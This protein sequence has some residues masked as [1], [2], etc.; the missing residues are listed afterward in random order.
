[1]SW[2]T[3]I[4]SMIAS[5]CFTLA[6]VHLLIWR[7][8]RETRAHAFFALMAVGTI[9]IAVCEVWSMHAETTAEYGVILR[10]GHV[11]YFMLVIS[12]VGFVR[13][14]LRAGKPWLAWA[15]CGLRTISLILNFIFTPN[16]NYREITALRQV[17]FLGE[18]ISI[19]EGVPNPWMLIGQASLLLL[20]I[21]TIDAMLT[22]WRRH[23]RRSA[24]VLSITIM[25]FV[26]MNTGQFVLILWGVLH[27]PLT[28]SIFFL[29]I[30][31]AMSFDLSDNVLRVVRL[32][33]DLRESEERMT[34]AANAV[35]FG[36]WIWNVS[37]DKVWCTGKLRLL[38]GFEPGEE[39]TPNLFF[40]RLHPEDHERVRQTL[41]KAL[42]TRSEYA[43]EY[44]II[45]SDGC[46]RWIAAFG[47]TEQ[48][49]VKKEVRMLGVCMDITQRKQMEEELRMS[50]ERYRSFIANSSESISR[51]DFAPPIPVNLPEKDQVDLIFERGFLVECNAMTA[52]QYGFPGVDEAIGA[53]L[54]M[55][56][57]RTKAEN[58]DFVLAW[59]RGHYCLTNK[60]SVEFDQQEN[61]RRFSNNLSG[62]IDNGLLL[63]AWGVSRDIT[64]QMRAEQEI[65]RQRHE[66]LH[67]NRISTMGLLASSLAH[68]LNQ[69]LG[70]ILRNAEAAE[71]FLQD[72]QPD[73]NELRAILSD[74][75]KD[76]QRAGE[77]ID[78]MR[79][80]IKKPNE[81]KHHNLN[82]EILANDVLTLVRPDAEMRQVQLT[83]LTTS[84]LPSVHGDRVQ[85]QQVLLNL[86]LNAM[87][88]LEGNSPESRHVTVDVHPVG[89]TVEVSVSDT[90]QGI[91]A[92]KLLCVFEPFFSSKPNGLGMGL[93]ISRD[94]I[95][96]HGGRLRAENDEAGGAIFTFSLPMAQEGYTR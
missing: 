25:L 38:F 14:Y 22:I 81:A 92:D 33:E 94:I 30:L 72:P 7:L 46:Y 76:D 24:L 85:L 51:F 79:I 47:R 8:R 80:L 91:S 65:L 45:L 41:R 6:A 93:A 58:V 86:L 23:D 26:V 12:L 52:R 43:G 87:D 32:S 15:T 54:A 74:I 70:A 96:S 34:L 63:G 11:P 59:I 49:G 89:E 75:R 78:R 83:M 50:D 4:W 28:P 31:A 88:A 39:I 53:R 9:L 3:V 95:D 67:V 37:Q 66:L 36:F 84:D 21:F 17:S 55:V 40:S 61:L 1:M 82:L 10:W 62:I 56:R 35:N 2:V 5:T 71:L 18:T 16:I 13:V 44:R 20:V 42:D 90:G 73:F 60:E 57:P 68:E 48:H 64:E 69:P 77:V 27:I 19:A 29:G